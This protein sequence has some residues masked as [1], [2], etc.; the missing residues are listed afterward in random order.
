[1]GS[2]RALPVRPA[3]PVRPPVA[4][5]VVPNNQFG[6]FSSEFGAKDLELLVRDFSF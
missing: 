5:P 6:V 1:V 4:P 3:G 2:S